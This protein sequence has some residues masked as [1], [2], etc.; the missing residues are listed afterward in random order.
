MNNTSVIEIFRGDDTD[1][2]G[3]QTIHGIITTDFDLTGCTVVF[4]YLD[5]TSS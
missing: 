1:A 3:Y 2:L 5:S 4:R